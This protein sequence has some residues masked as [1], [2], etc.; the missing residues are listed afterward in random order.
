VKLGGAVVIGHRHCE[1][2]DVGRQT[3]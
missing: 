2:L 1:A 3:C